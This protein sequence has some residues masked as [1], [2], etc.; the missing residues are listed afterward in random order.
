M[1]I[2]ETETAYI[3]H[4]QRDESTKR[5]TK[6]IYR[7]LTILLRDPI[8]P[9]EMR[10]TKIWPNQNWDAIWGNLHKTLI[11]EA[12]KGEWYR[13]IHDIIPTN[14]RLNKINLTPNDKCDRT[15]T[16]THRITVCG[17][18]SKS[19]E[20]TEHKMASL[21]HM[22]PRHIPDEW[23]TKPQ[24][25]TCPPQ[26]HRAIL[27]LVAQITLYRGQERRDLTHIDYMDF[28]RRQQ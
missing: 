6:R 11:S 21:L 10:I 1:R 9:T 22:D 16:I 2:L 3:E 23:T 20:W 28:L 7:T 19:W 17:E 25:Q 14:E 15:D 26:R 5:Y 18:G 24:F 12:E 4:Q 13:T 8:E 27:W